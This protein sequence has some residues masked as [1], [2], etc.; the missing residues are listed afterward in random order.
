[1]NRTSKLASVFACLAALAPIAAQAAGEL[2]S[3]YTEIE[4][5]QGPGN[6]RFV[7]DFTPAPNTDKIE[8]VVEWTASITAKG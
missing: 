6:G 2:P 1:M 3:G 8:A 7:T 5:I 4:Y